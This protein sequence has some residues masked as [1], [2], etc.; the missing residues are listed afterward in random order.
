MPRIYIKLLKKDLSAGMIKIGQTRLK[1]IQHMYGVPTNISETKSKLTYDYG[2]LRIEFDKVRYFRDWEYDYSHPTAY[3]DEI[4]DLRPTAQDAD[5]VWTVVA[6]ARPVVVD[7]D[8]GALRQAVAGVGVPAHAAPRV[9]H[10]WALAW[11][12][13]PSIQNSRKPNE[14]G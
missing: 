9:S 10:A 12:S 11:K 7:A 2:D 14:R 13:R 8:G 6:L 1:K 5:L 3:S 4:D